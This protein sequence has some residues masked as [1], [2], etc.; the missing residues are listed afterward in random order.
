M[1]MEIMILRERVVSESKYYVCYAVIGTEYRSPASTQ[2]VAW[3]H[4][5]WPKC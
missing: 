2:K 5:L 3:K 1:E 4:T